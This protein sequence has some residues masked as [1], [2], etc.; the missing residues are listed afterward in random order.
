M[1]ETLLLKFGPSATCAGSAM[2]AV[3]VDP[4][5]GEAGRPTLLFRKEQPDR[6]GGGRT[7]AYDV[8]A[9]GERFLLIEPVQA[10]GA[11]PMVVVLDWFEELRA[12][13]RNAAETPH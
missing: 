10:S 4:T 7:M 13:A 1:S 12:L 8:S 2:M 5:T 11:Q 6:L 3:D 9:D